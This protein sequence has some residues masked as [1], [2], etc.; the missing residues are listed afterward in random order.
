MVAILA[1]ITST[2]CNIPLLGQIGSNKTVNNSAG[3]VDT[4]KSGS[5]V[6]KLDDVHKAVIQIEAEGTFLDPKLGL[7]VNA[8]GRG[9]GFIIDPSGIAVTNNH[10]VTGAAVVRVWVDGEEEP[11]IAQVLG[12]SECNDLA[13]IKIEGKDF[14]Y[15]NWYDEEVTTG[16][17]IYLAGFP[18]GEPEFS[19]TKG[20]VS[21]AH[22]TG[23]TSWTAITGGVLAH[24]ATSNPGNSG[25]PLVDAKGQVVGVNFA[26]R[27][28]TNQYFAIS[29]ATAKPIVEKL[30]NQDNFE[31]IGVNGTVVSND[32]N[33]ISGVWVSSVASGSIADKAGL[34]PGDIIIQL[35]G[36]VV[37]T[38]GTMEDYCSVI[39]SHDAGTALSI[40]VLRWETQE[41]L[42]GQ[43]NGRPLAVK[44]ATSSSDDTSTPS[45]TNTIT[46][47]PYDGSE[48]S[49]KIILYADK[50]GT[51]SA[52]YH[53]SE[54]EK[55]GFSSWCATSQDT[56]EEN[57]KNTDIAISIDGQK[58]ET[59]QIK[60]ILWR[61][62]KMYCVHYGGYFTL[63]AGTYDF[64]TITTFH[65]SINDGL[66]DYPA[67][68]YVFNDTVI[69]K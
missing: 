50:P 5:L 7:Q 27:A 64:Q 6:T 59:S 65:T 62:D 51:Q 32:D 2:A 30:R 21:K 44:G 58:I 18:L 45:S 36:L 41:V 1:I 63:P 14:N 8:A 47:T 10:V 29:A 48:V 11:R 16:L 68:D 49:Y 22:T 54:G 61:S 24:D 38:D 3:N 31:S 17:E 37:G 15:L 35:E 53:F 43:L 4:G 23:N 28:E 26:G 34:K 13:V 56:L 19:L 33:S 40:T 12:Y 20:I 69:V 67:G 39:R 66:S 60:G 57:V 55:I 42:E 52:E 25:G 46:I 9:S